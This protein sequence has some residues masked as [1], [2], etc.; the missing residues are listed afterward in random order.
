MLIIQIL[1]IFQWIFWIYLSATSV[2]LLFYSICSLFYKNKYPEK[3]EKQ[4]KFLVL[5]PAYKEDFVIFHVAEDSILQNYP[6]E[7]YDVC[8]IADSL[9][10]ETISKLKQL[11]I[12][13]LEDSLDISTKAKA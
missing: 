8:I 2:Y 5:I 12:N 10:E 1:K 3:I 9:K 4:R 6:Q 7:L 11:P 13:V